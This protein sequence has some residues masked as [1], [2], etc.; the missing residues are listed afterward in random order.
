MQVVVVADT[1]LRSGLTNLPGPLVDA[2]GR[3]DAII[4]AGD[5]VSLAALSGFR[6]LGT[7]HAVLGNNDHELAGLLPG[8]LRLELGGVRVAV[9]HDSGAARG[10]AARMAHR[11]PG[12]QLVIF[13]HSHVPV[14]ER[15]LAGQVLFNPGSPTQ[16]RSQPHPT[17]GRL[18]LEDGRIVERRIEALG[19][20]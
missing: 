16:R 9:L 18:C 19:P 3:S 10:R 17:F 12:A 6:E 2:L 11:Y 13:G 14:N 4:H 1:H 8:E 20:S 15:G 7:V 5:V